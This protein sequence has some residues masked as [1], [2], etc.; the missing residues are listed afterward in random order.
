MTAFLRAV[1]RTTGQ[2]DQ[3]RAPAPRAPHLVHKKASNHHSSV[4]QLLF[5]TMSGG[6]SAPNT[7]ALIDDR[8]HTPRSWRKPLE[9]H[10]ITTFLIPNPATHHR[11]LTVPTSLLHRSLTSRRRSRPIDI[12][13]RRS[14]CVASVHQS[15]RHGRVGREVDIGL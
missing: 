7:R 8:I 6:I 1:L 15:L 12:T 3:H 2:T 5:L 14:P 10:S 9:T 13:G 11:H 4:H